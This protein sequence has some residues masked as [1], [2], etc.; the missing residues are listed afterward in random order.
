MGFKST[1]VDP[2]FHCYC[3]LHLNDKGDDDTSSFLSVELIMCCLGIKYT[4]IMDQNGQLM[5]SACMV[6]YYN[7][8]VGYYIYHYKLRA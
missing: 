1:V 6:V 2:T 8:L 7:T 3:L 4:G 5:N